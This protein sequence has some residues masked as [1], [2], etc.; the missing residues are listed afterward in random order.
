MDPSGL[1][2]LE[3]GAARVRSQETPRIWIQVRFWIHFHLLFGCLGSFGMNLHLPK[4]TATLLTALG[5]AA[6]KLGAAQGMIPILHIQLGLSTISDCWF[7]LTK[8]RGIPGPSRTGLSPMETGFLASVSLLLTKPES[9][10]QPRIRQ[11]TSTHMDGSVKSCILVCSLYRTR[12]RGLSPEHGCALRWWSS[13]AAFPLF[14]CRTSGAGH[15]DEGFPAAA[16]SGHPDTVRPGFGGAPPLLEEHC[17][18]SPQQEAQPYLHCMASLD[19]G[20]EAAETRREVRL[21]LNG[22]EGTFRPV[23]YATRRKPAQEVSP[24]MSC[25]LPKLVEARSPSYCYVFCTKATNILFW[26]SWSS[27]KLTWSNPFPLAWNLHLLSGQKTPGI[28]LTAISYVSPT[29]TQ[30][31]LLSKFYFLLDSWAPGFSLF[32]SPSLLN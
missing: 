7:L 9:A 2:R 31:F 19:S 21:R 18:C 6:K 16:S 24:H 23:L 8:R 14:H 32:F 29:S 17:T 4:H 15:S 30:Q 12:I 27:P 3:A 25:W 13:P 22:R 10:A 28:S 26:K 1:R 11:H 20:K 5:L